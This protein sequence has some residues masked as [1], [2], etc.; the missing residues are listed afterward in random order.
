[1]SEKFYDENFENN[2]KASNHLRRADYL[3]VFL[4][5]IVSAF[6][7]VGVPIIW[8]ATDY[9]SGNPTAVGGF[10]FGGLVIFAGIIL[11]LIFCGIYGLLAFILSVSIERNS[12]FRALLAAIS[13][14][15]VMLF[16]VFLFQM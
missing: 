14:L 16:L 15:V 2:K 11:C 1:M 6:L 13:F 8:I 4:P 10:D 5:M 3:L 12:T 9:L 7:L